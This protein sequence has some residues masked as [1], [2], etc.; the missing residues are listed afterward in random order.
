MKHKYK[1]N[2]R[3][4]FQII[5]GR[6]EGEKVNFPIRIINIEEEMN[7]RMNSNFNVVDVVVFLSM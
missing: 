5:P 6:E 1:L 4:I 3:R 7:K 2:L